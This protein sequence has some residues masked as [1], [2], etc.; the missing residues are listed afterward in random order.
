MGNA[1]SGGHSPVAPAS[2]KHGP[3]TQPPSTNSSD[4]NTPGRQR[5]GSVA[6]MGT[7]TPRMVDATDAP[8]PAVLSRFNASA[9]S[10]N[11][12]SPS[13][14]GERRGSV[15]LTAAEVPGGEL[16]QSFKGPTECQLDDESVR[17]KPRP[18]GGR[19]Y[20]DVMPTPIAKLKELQE[21]AATSP[22]ASNSFRG[23]RRSQND[24]ESEP[25]PEELASELARRSE[26]FDVSND[27]DARKVRHR[28][29]SIIE[30][31]PFG[32]AGREKRLSRE[33]A[34]EMALMASASEDADDAEKEVVKIA[35]F[36]PLE[37][38]LGS[39]SAARRSDLGSSTI[40]TSDIIKSGVLV[41]SELTASLQGTISEPLQ[42]DCIGTFTCRGMESGQMKTNQDYA[43]S[44]MPFADIPGT[45]VF[46]VCDG[47]GRTGDDVSQ[48][49]L[50]SLAFELEENADS[51]LD[52]PGHTIAR[53]FQAVND[54]LSAMAAEPTI[55]VD[56]R[57]SG[58]CCVLAYLR[59]GSLWVG[60]V[61]DCR[62]V[63]G[64][65]H[66]GNILTHA[67]STDHVV[68]LPLERKRIEAA[69]GMVRDSWLAEDGA[70]MAAKLYENLNNTRLGPGLSISR[71]FGDLNAKRFG[72]IPHPELT[73]HKVTRRDLYL[74]LATDGVWEFLDSDDVIDV[75]HK[76]C[77]SGEPAQ[78]ACKT[79][80]AKAARQWAV[81]EGDYRDDI[82]I[83][84]AYLQPLMQG[85]SNDLALVRHCDPDE[86]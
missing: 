26:K 74:V 44:A 58:T 24:Q 28:G 49:V 77:T 69:G 30:D 45:A 46:I 9:E 80:I 2:K 13:P 1:C 16:P 6:Q 37:G 85:L 79:I 35:K 73:Y 11:A 38:E 60:G 62:A 57:E 72:L 54:H 81:H 8:A 40:G 42:N 31:S 7:R 50:N 5:R 43:C 59:A 84:V 55:E 34:A 71:A 23:N 63:L 61:G 83:V 21:A 66:E 10:P 33:A 14:R 70:R 19:R 86:L 27:S 64:T 47:H 75:V 15:L 52:E 76:C 56:A 53:S 67:L 22:S 68:D 17:S 48:E 82:T 4:F 3:S 78:V 20:S 36:V 32:V 51:L 18:R 29:N 65:E 39:V 12:V 25:L 41:S